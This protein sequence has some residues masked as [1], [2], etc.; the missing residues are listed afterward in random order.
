MAAT[1]QQHSKKPFLERTII[2][3]EDLFSNQ[4][5]SQDSIKVLPALKSLLNPYS[6]VSVSQNV[7]DLL[8]L[9]SS[10]LSAYS[11]KEAVD[12][13]KELLSYF[14]KDFLAIKT[15]FTDNM[16]GSSFSLKPFA[17]IERVCLMSSSYITLLGY[18]TSN[19]YHLKESD[20]DYEQSGLICSV[21]LTELLDA[22]NSSCDYVEQCMEKAGSNVY[23]VVVWILKV[24]SVLSHF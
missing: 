19:L 10:R 11:F 20:P 7:L 5:S 3:D 15:G 18:F 2:A 23:N 17:M 9:D 1:E 13:I 6:G 22:L 21:F 8:G 4:L 16:R 24:L 14:R 12:S